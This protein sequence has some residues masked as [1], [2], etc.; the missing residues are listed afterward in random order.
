MGASDPVANASD[1]DCAD[2]ANQAEAEEY[3][4]SGDPYNLDADNDG[5]ACEDL[6]CPCSY[7]PGGGGEE[8]PHPPPPPP[9]PPKLRKS[10]ARDAALAKASQF[11]RHS[12]GG[13]SLH[14]QRCGRR[15]AYRVD[16]SFRGGA[17]GPDR[18]VSCHGR[19]VVRG[20]GT[21]VSSARLHVRCRSEPVLSLAR[22]QQ[23]IVA[24]ARSIAG[25][26]VVVEGLERR[27]PV[28][29]AALATWM[30]ATGEREECTVELLAYM[31]R[32]GEISVTHRPVSCE[33]APGPASSPTPG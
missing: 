26:P 23:A 19:V 12:G 33:P 10:V 32:D 27:S 28:R 4:L 11:N 14:L 6:P 13:R 18:V 1:Y 24:E 29:F 17:R 3:L 5:I 22:A 8:G 31:Y 21:V 25:K 16:C 9:P 2:F 20:E 15:S 30:R 7:S